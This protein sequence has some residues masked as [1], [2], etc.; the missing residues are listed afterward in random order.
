[1]RWANPYSPRSGHTDPISQFSPNPARETPQ[2]PSRETFAPVNV[3][4][5]GYRARD[6][7]RIPNGAT[8][9]TQS[10]K[11]LPLDHESPS[12]TL[13]EGAFMQVTGSG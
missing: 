13:P 7:L 3:S 10:P 1:M 11:I 2:L 5:G 8:L 12:R 6:P 9:G 4:S